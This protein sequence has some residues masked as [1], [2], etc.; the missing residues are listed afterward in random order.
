VV[1]ASA[2]SRF[3]KKMV[4]FP[5]SN[6]LFWINLFVFKPLKETAPYDDRS[7]F[8]LRMTTPEGSPAVKYTDRL[9]RKFR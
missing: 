2:L 9:C 6:C 8:V 3:K 7:G 5:Y 4:E 1:G